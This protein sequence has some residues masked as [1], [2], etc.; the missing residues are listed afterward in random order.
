MA[1]ALPLPVFVSNPVQLIGDVSL[2]LTIVLMNFVAAS[3][4]CALMS[5]VLKG[6]TAGLLRPVSAQA[7]GI[8]LLHRAL[9]ILIDNAA[10]YTPQGGSVKVRL[11]AHSKYAVA[12]VSDT[13]M[14][15]AKEDVAHIFDR[16]WRAD[17]ARSREHGGA[18][19][20]LSIAKWI[21]KMHGGS[22]DVE[23]ELGKGSVFHLRIPLVRPE[24]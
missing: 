6:P 23:S 18:G 24:G 11:E 7:L 3:E 14:G 19:L 22:I 8:V 4:L 10:K 1:A 15:I 13:G 9:L 21:V 17:K 12:S 16:F 2:D 20:G 5:F